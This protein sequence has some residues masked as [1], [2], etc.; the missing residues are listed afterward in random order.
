M[1]VEFSILL[2]PNLSDTIIGNARSRVKKVQIRPKVGTILYACEFLLLRW[3][4]SPCL[5]LY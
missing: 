5:I 4:V 3:F 2:A 1:F